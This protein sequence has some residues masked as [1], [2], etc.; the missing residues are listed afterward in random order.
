[1]ILA[2]GLG[3][4]LRPLTDV[5]A[6]ALVPVGDRPV[7]GHALDVLRA[8]GVTR[9]VI[10]AHHR[11]GDLRAFAE[12]RSVAVSME[13]ELL[14]TAGGVARARNLLGEGDVLVWNGDV[15]ADI[16]V[17]SL[18][19]AHAAAPAEATLTIRARA[20]GE[21]NVGVDAAGR[22]VRIRQVRTGAEV[23]GGEFLGVSVLAEEL[24]RRLP[25]QGCLVGDFWIPALE[26]GAGLR[27][28][29]HAGAWHDIGS[30]SAYLA[31]NLAWLRARRAAS[32]LGEGA[33]A[34]ASVVLDGALLGC[35]ACVAGA[36]RVERTVVWPGATATAPV[37]DAVVLPAPGTGGGRVVPVVMP[38]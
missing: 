5:C 8:G 38:Q 32:W 16:D 11:P 24:R 7:L 20:A 10:N 1:M 34:E 14:G 25:G 26:R 2:A 29:E 19:R 13:D 21:G 30:L 4:R 12:A 3:T 28:F 36:G 15:V 18:L 33:K 6:K 9:C 31:A 35:G 17:A 22:V 37:S 27:A 23:Q